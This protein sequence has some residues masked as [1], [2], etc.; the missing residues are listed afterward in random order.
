MTS[1]SIG[2][3]V[4]CR[5]GHWIGSVRVQTPNP[6]QPTSYTLKPE[7]NH[8]KFRFVQFFGLYPLPFSHI[9]SLDL[10]SDFSWFRY[11]C[12]TFQTDK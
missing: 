5:V 4:H 9:F 6:N 10:R 3:V 1:T 11:A 2:D 8:I 12:Y 7:H